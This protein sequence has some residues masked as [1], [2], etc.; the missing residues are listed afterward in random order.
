M[1]PSFS[2]VAPHTAHTASCSLSPSS[3]GAR[4]AVD[5]IGVSLYS[6]KPR[7]ATARH[8]GCRTG[9]AVIAEPN[10]RQ[11][12]LAALC[13]ERAVD[14]SKCPSDS[15]SSEDRRS[16][17]TQR[18]CET[19]V[20]WSG[21]A[22][23]RC[24]PVG[25]ELRRERGRVHPGPPRSL[26]RCQ[27]R[28]VFPSLTLPSATHRA[29]NSRRQSSSSLSILTLTVPAWSGAASNSV[30]LASMI[31]ASCSSVE[32]PVRRRASRIRTASSG[33]TRHRLCPYSIL[34]QGCSR[35]FASPSMARTSREIRSRTC[36]LRE[37]RRSGRRRGAEPSR[38]PA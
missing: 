26:H 12:M 17:L 25:D 7:T 36:L 4:C 24:R 23:V 13:P 11:D 38:G 6:R 15:S 19:A 29:S 31:V 5:T 2:T 33:S 14:G 1:S 34:S 16:A 27:R 22:S 37:R 30:A 10:E 21:S 9:L 28:C 3:A 32:P 8:P 18:P 35:L 20:P